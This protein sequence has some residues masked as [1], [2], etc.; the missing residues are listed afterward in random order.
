MT[1][2]ISCA[3]EKGGVGKT[4]TTVNLGIGLARQGKSVLLIDADPRGIRK[5]WLPT[6]QAEAQLRRYESCTGRHRT[7]ME[8]VELYDTFIGIFIYEFSEMIKEHQIIY[9]EDD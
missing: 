7:R 4:M 1:K 3:H 2:V 8:S 5:I 9:G 6:L